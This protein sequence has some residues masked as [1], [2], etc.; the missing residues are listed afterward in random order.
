MACV[1]TRVVACVLALLGAGVVAG[2]AGSPAPAPGPP[3]PALAPATGT[4]R[5]AGVCPSTVVIQDLWE[6]GADQAAWY[7]LVGPDP[8]VDVARKRVVGPLVAGGKDTGVKIEI[9]SGGA[10]IGF[11]TAPAQMYLDRS[12]TLGA[13]HTD[14]LISTSASQPVTAVF[15]LMTKS[16]HM[17]MWD[18]ASHPDWRGIADIG[19]SNAKVV[20]AKDNIFP[21]LLVAKGLIKPDQVDAGYT[22][23]PARFVADP[24]I[25]QQGYAT[26][27]PYIYEHEVPAWDKP[28]RYQLLADVGYDIYPQ[29]LGVRT[30]DLE[31]LAPCLTRLVPILQRAQR[32][33]ITDPG[34]TNKLIVDTVARFN[35]GWTYS[36]G[37]ADHAVAVMKRLK[38]VAND[39]S[40]ALGG[41]DP[42]RIQASIDTLGPILAN[43]GAKVKQ[44][45]RA[46]DIATNRFIDPRLRLN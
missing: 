2:C 40:G 6:P 36:A 29:A 46:D 11:V 23:A 22:G 34:P 41:M 21:A 42:R 13:A 38:L 3:A 37:V 44:G 14:Q 20:V 39:S 30:G 27:E 8:T 17:L 9:R 5:L 18:P 43:S 32:D 1:S 45:L 19:R 15:A 31:Q 7:Q 16:P 24:T 10:A 28:V 35:D 4:D 26:N 25:A 12:I 33:F